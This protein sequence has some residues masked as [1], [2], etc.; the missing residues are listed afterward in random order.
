MRVAWICYYPGG[1][2]LERPKINSDPI[3]H[4]VPWIS[5][6]APVVA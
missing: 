3:F 2:F 6:Q 5:A 4:P 1:I